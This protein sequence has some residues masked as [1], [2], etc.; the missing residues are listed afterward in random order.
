MQRSHHILPIGCALTIALT[1]IT[2]TANAQ[3]VAIVGGA[4]II[5]NIAIQD[6]GKAPIMSKHLAEIRSEDSRW[7]PLMAA[8]SA[9][10]EAA[11]GLTAKDLLTAAFSLDIDTLAMTA[12]T[13]REQV[14]GLSG[15]LALK[16]A[17]P[18]SIAQLKQALKL[19]YGSQKLA[20]VSDVSIAG[21]P[22]LKIHASTVEDPNVYLTIT[23]NKRTVL[24]AFNTKSL[25]DGL[26]RIGARQAYREKD[27]IVQA[28][29]LL[30][31]GS[32]I[33]IAGIV[34]PSLRAK[35]NEYVLSM[36]KQAAQN[37]KLAITLGFVR[38]FQGVKN[39]GMGLQLDA[40]AQVSLM[41]TLGSQ[42]EAQQASI[43]LN[44]MV[45]PMVHAAMLQQASPSQ[46]APKLDGIINVDAKA[47]VLKIGLRLTEE[48]MG[49]ILKQTAAR[50]QP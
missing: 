22:G 28:R 11:T 13:P 29:K 41:G 34:P 24:I 7:G 5:G 10:F 1:S 2:G 16:L 35:I 49:Q 21:T 42:Q 30:P 23:P 26:Q 19:E 36:T 33:Q 45:I 25:A 27:G 43:L 38:L 37:P 8:R 50:R 39:M 9:R 48:Q 20:G 47:D 44:S 17:K 40:G 32:Q 14:R 12:A 3:Q 6:L 46:P 4:D 15:L 31:A 18:I